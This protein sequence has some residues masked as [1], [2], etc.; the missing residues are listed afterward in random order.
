M[1][2]KINSYYKSFEGFLLCNAIQLLLGL[3]FDVFDFGI[4]PVDEKYI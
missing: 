1:V 3:D 2:V 4:E